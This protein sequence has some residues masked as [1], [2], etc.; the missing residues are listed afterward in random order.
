MVR[1]YCSQ[2][3]E[4]LLR[5]ILTISEYGNALIPWLTSGYWCIDTIKE[6]HHDACL[7]DASEMAMA[8]RKIG[9]STHFPVQAI[10]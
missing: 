2:K 3:V 6:S 7:C 8:Q 1:L 4:H 10:L 5:K 9:K